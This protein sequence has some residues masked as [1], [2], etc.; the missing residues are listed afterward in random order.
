VDPGLRRGDGYLV[1]P[2]KAGIHDCEGITPGLAR[3]RRT[4]PWLVAP[5]TRDLTSHVDFTTLRREAGHAG[6]STVS[7]SSQSRFLLDLVERSGLVGE[8][9]RPERLRD[10]L[11]LKSL[12]VPGGLGSSHTVIVFAKNAA[13]EGRAS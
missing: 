8:L 5:G 2:A 13:S 10:R 3:S 7:V 1:I 4:P 9:D 6:L 12:L 11:A